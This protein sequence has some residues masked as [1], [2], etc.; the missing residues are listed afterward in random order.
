MGDLYSDRPVPRRAR[1]LAGAL[2]VLAALGGG[3]SRTPGA[4]RADRRGAM[5]EEI[6]RL[7]AE[8]ETLGRREQGLLG[9]VARLG[10]VLNLR[11]REAQ[12]ASLRL[13]EVRAGLAERRR[14]IVLLEAAQEARGRILAGRLREIYKRGTDVELRRLFGGGTVGDYLQGLRYASFLSE[15]D[16]KLLRGWHDDG[17]R[18]RAEAETMIKEERGLDLARAE[19]MR[20]ATELEK[21]RAERSRLLDAIQMDRAKHQEAIDDLERASRELGKLVQTLGGAARGPALDVRKFRGLLDWPADGPVSARYGD[22]VHPRFRTVVPHPGL[23]ID[24]P[25]GKAFRAIFDGRVIFASWLHGYGLTVIVDHGNGVVSIYAHASILLAG[26]GDDVTRGQVLGRVGETGSLRGPYLYFEM[27]MEG[28]P[29]DPSA[30]LR[31]R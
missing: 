27:R 18:L 12:E 3:A 7:R 4:E 22:S 23:D 13:E 26:A 24:A 1:A 6:L 19:A 20:A 10:A 5:Q 16:A 21:S 29:V 30:W 14:R 9:E 17:N 8:M 2:L 31:R 15:R 28:K 11:A 25:E